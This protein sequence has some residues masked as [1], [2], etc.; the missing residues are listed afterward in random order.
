MR[1]A[2]SGSLREQ[3]QKARSPP[4]LRLVATSKDTSAGGS[5]LCVVLTHVLGAVVP[6]SRRGAGFHGAGRSACVITSVTSSAVR[7]HE[8]YSAISGARS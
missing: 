4:E 7:S 8:K 2:T 1:C 6:A 3:E 5:N